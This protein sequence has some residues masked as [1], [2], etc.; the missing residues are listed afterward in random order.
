MARPHAK[1]RGALMER[2]IDEAYL[3]RKL[4]RGPTYISQRMMGK[5]PWAMDEAYMIM[6]L[7]HAPLEM[8][9]EYF[10]PK[11]VSA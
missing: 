1:L 8:L 9:A 2:D 11:G 3:A 7:I 4:L 6:D 10:P 5:K